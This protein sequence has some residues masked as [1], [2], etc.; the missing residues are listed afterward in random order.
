MC[1]I[2]GIECALPVKSQ[3]PE[4]KG[5]TR[6]RKRRRSGKNGTK[7]DDA[8]RPSV[9]DHRRHGHE[10]LRSDTNTQRP[11]SGSNTIVED[12]VPSYTEEVLGT[13]PTRGRVQG[14]DQAKIEESIHV[15]GP[16]ISNDATVV[17]KYLLNLP[18]NISSRHDAQLYRSFAS[19]SGRTSVLFTPI[20]KEPEG[21]SRSRS[22]GSE[23]CQIITQ[24]LGPN[25]VP[26]LEL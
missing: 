16:T 8:S 10:S 13:S 5:T 18:D 4:N 9:E 2:H 11:M 12:D 19:K 21:M 20:R 15:V 1:R 23:Q 26:I 22:K 25:M 7:R 6:S 14:A 17:R 24:L 3:I